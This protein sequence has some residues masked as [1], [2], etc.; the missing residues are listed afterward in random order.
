M[1]TCAIWYNMQI[2]LIGAINT[3]INYH[4]WLAPTNNGFVVP[5]VKAQPNTKIS[6]MKKPSSSQFALQI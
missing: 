3:L 5:I 4:S 2:F 1:Q 6:S